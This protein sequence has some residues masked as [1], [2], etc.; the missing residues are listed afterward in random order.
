MKLYL[1]ILGVQCEWST[2]TVKNCSKSCGGGTRLKIRKK[3]VE[4]IASTCNGEAVMLE[5]CNE[6]DCP[7]ILQI[8]LLF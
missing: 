6:F 7:G 8:A 4:E 5:N 3:V 1:T 2:W